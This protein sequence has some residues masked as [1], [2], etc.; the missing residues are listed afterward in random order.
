MLRMEDV[1]S[2]AAANYTGAVWGVLT[3]TNAAGLA[4]APAVSTSL[5]ESPHADD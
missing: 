2:G 5:V 4:S 1:L 3:A